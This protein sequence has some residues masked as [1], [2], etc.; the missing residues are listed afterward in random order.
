MARSERSGCPGGN[1]DGLLSCRAAIPPYHY[2]LLHWAA[3]HV[4]CLAG[5][6]GGACGV[7]KYE[8]LQHAKIPGQGRAP[9]WAVSLLFP[10]SS[11]KC[12]PSLR[13]V[14]TARYVAVCIASRQH[15]LRSRMS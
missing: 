12:M 1:F 3:A 2:G 7:L 9:D 5:A 10:S 8:A 14:Y 4:L 13:L 6:I 15:L 11:P